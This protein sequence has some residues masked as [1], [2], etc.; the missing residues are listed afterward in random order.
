VGALD[1]AEP[2]QHVL[3]R[4]AGQDASYHCPDA[5]AVQRHIVAIRARIAKAGDHAPITVAKLQADVDL[6]LD[7]WSYLHCMT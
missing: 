1:T 4:V 6:L 5:E 7:R 2:E 3:E